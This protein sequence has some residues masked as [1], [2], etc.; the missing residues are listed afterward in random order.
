M[1][2]ELIDLTRQIA[3]MQ[4]RQI[5]S[6][7]VRDYLKSGPVILDASGIVTALY[8]DIAQQPEML[9]EAAKRGLAALAVEQQKAIK[10]VAESPHPAAE[11]LPEKPPNQTE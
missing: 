7:L 4:Q 3:K 10:K 5:E 9:Q 8:P 2:E 11:V 6:D 1:L